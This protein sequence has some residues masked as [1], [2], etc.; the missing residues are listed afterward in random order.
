MVAELILRGLWALSNVP[1]GL[2][3]PR[4]RP[5]NAAEFSAER[6]HSQHVGWLFV[7]QPKT[8]MAGK[9]SAY[10]PQVPFTSQEGSPMDS[11]NSQ[12]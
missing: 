9:L 5:F 3:L 7:R 6:K 2:K 12:K 8:K 10:Q 4:E 1:F 11:S